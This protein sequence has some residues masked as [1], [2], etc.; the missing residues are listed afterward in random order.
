M[1]DRKEKD[2]AEVNEGRFLLDDVCRV[3]QKEGRR[4]VISEVC[5]YEGVEASGA[6]LLAERVA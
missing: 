5:A 6:E 4:E 1:E 2:I 3:F